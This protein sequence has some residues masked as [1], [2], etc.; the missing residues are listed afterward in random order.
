[1]IKNY[2]KTAFRAMLKNGAYSLLNIL[3]LAVGITCAALILLWVEDEVTYNHQFEKRDR[4]YITK[5]NQT[6]DGTTF[7]FDAT[8]GKLGPAIQSEIAG[9]KNTARVN[10]GSQLL[11]KLNDKSIYEQG[12]YA[13][14]SLFSMLKLPF[15][16]GKADGA[17]NQ[18]YSVVISEKMA[19]KFFG[20]AAALGKTLKINDG[21]DYTVSG[22][23]RD[24][25]DNVSFKFDWVAPFK[26]YMDDN[27]WLEQWGN[28]G[29]QTYV[30]LDPHA[31]LDAINRQL[32]GFVQ[33]KAQGTTA[34]LFIF[35]MNKWRLYNKFTNGQS[36]GGRIKYVKLFSTIAWIIIIIAC[37]NFMN[38]ATAR[39]EKRAKEVGVRKV[40]GA[41]KHM[42][43]SQFIGESLFISFITV[44]VAVGLIFLALPAFNKLVDKDLGFAFTAI[45]IL[46]LL[47]I[48][49][50][51]GL[52][53]G[54][55]PAFYL[56][57]FRPILVL[58][59]L[60][61]KTNFGS[62]FIR[63]ILVTLQ[64]TIS[65]GLIISTLI[66]YNQVQYV[67]SRELGYNKNNLV[68]LN[69]KGQMTAHFDA[70]RNDLINSG[71]AQNAALSRSMVLQMGS[72]TGDFSWEGKDPTKKV[73]ITIE[74]V[75]PQYVSTMGMKL[76]GG[77]DFY[78]AAAT[79]SGNVIINESLAKIMAKN[80]NVVGRQLNYGGGQKFTVVGVVKDFVY[81]NMYADATPLILFCDPINT[82]FLTIRLK[83]N[84]NI[85]NALTKVESVI[86]ANNPA[87][88]VSYN[89]VDD[90]FNQY[91]KSE[92]LIGKLAGVFAVL[93]IVI[94]C[95]G[96]FGLSAFTAERRTR[97]I[98]IRKVLGASIAGLATL[99]SK[100]F[101]LMVLLSCVISFPLSWWMMHKWLQDYQYRAAINFWVFVVAGLSAILIAVITVSF[102]A[103]KAALMNPVKSLRSE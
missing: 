17:F 79:D 37:I 66:I 30:E 58:K 86:K 94:S 60:K 19:H 69:L 64:F 39:S 98:G 88:P 40:I 102:Q 72:N 61:Q 42:L 8:P 38:L 10:F 89:F 93:A 91:F 25:P 14:S 84:V 71:A 12:I 44:L 35:P 41:Q 77:R 6:Y 1:M 80:G 11:F 36:D 67:R 26:L 59:G 95:L 70:I 53:A 90:Q 57:S 50:I 63:Q 49:L 24:L 78:P 28:N 5:N 97:E 48:G 23:I 96:L 43:I 54:S 9:I 4:L 76:Q 31:N 51:C 75:S 32:N 81:N 101:I 15:A 65:I 92:V 3:G 87:Y 34:R 13:D 47:L 73:L 22:V 83:D 100:D 29:I 7:T 33:T 99:L 62:G 74:T 27:K 16:E 46:G 68:Y 21:Q 103:V 56:S 82:N 45:H 18:V 52:L 85:N 20:D 2:I 55:Y